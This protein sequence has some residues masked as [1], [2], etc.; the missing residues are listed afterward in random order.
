M[1]ALYY[2][3]DPSHSAWLP[4][5]PFHAL[6]GWECPACGGQRALHAL[7]HGRLGE[8]V[9]FN[10]FL[11]VSVPYFLAVAWTSLDRGRVAGASA[12]DRAAPLGGLCLLR[13]VRPLVGGAQ[14]S[15]GEFVNPRTAADPIKN[16]PEFRTVLLAAEWPQRG[17]AS[18]LRRSRQSS[19]S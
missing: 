12:A 19:S 5:C 13:A 17:Y 6:T 18:G 15:G 1:A 9:Q 16:G 8:A 2:A 10:L 7:L 14:P 11:V 3:V 4:Q